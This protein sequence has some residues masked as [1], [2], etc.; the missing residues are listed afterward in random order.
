MCVTE[1]D[2]YYLV[3]GVCLAF[4][5]IFLV[6]FILPTARKLQRE[7]LEYLTFVKT[8]ST[9]NLRSAN[10]RVAG[11]NELKVASYYIHLP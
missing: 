9:W 11:D 6:A 10:V 3:C 2:G 5:V 4:G 8:S 7:W 1:T